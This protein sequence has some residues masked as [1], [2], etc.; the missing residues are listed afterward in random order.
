MLNVFVSFAEED[1]AYVD[2]LQD[3]IAD[4]TQI[5]LYR[6]E[7][8]LRPGTRLIEKITEAIKRADFV[9][10]LIT[11][12]SARSNWIQT[13]IGIAIGQKKPIVPICEIGARVP[14]ALHGIELIRLDPTNIQP[15]IAQAAMYL[16]RRAQIKGDQTVLAIAALITMWVYIAKN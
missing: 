5:Y 9:V 14:A 8:D 7:N 4:P 12:R 10:A 15:P 6:F 11:P 2:R 16:Q 3:A 1:S 13:E